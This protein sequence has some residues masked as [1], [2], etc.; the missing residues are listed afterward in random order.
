M[1]LWTSSLNKGDMLLVCLYVDDLIFIENNPTMFNEF[2]EV[3]V[4]EFE[5]TNIG[6][7]SCYLGIAVKQT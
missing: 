4:W 6:L 5:M 1:P 3:M 7:M 2:K